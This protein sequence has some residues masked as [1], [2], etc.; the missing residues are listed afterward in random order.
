M[1]PVR[2]VFLV[3]VVACLST[4]WSVPPVPVVWI[5]DNLSSIGGR[6]V[7]VVGAPR[8]VETPVGPAIEFD[9]KGDGLF[10]DLNPIAGLERFTVEALIEPAADGPA[11]QRFLHLAEQ[12]SD[13]RV[14]LETRILPGATWC[15]DTYLRH[16]PDSLTLIDRA[17]THRADAWY[18]VALVYDGAKMKHFVDSVLDAEGSVRFAPIGQGRTSIG[19]RQNKVSWFKGRMALVRVTPEALTPERL[20]RVS[21][22]TTRE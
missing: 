22:K 21:R 9:G 6:A 7:T 12:G 10:L 14:M 8:V 16:D 1:A 13:N 19:V 4:A 17:R 20:L 11:E 3:S 15:L 2:A 18:A 5:L